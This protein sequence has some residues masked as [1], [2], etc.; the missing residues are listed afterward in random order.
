M[1]SWKER[2]YAFLL[3]RL[4]GPILTRKSLQKLH[5]CLDV[6]VIEG[7]YVLTDIAL[8][9]EYISHKLLAQHGLRVV[10][11]SIRRLEV[12][13]SLPEHGDVERSSSLA[14]RA[15]KLGS[16]SAASD[17]KTKQPSVSL[18]VQVVVEGVLISVEACPNGQPV[19]YS[20]AANEQVDETSAK[21]FLSS[22]L[23]AA[24]SS[25]RL[26]IEFRD[27]R[28]QAV[29]R[30]ELQQQQW[31]EIRA[32]SASY[33]DVM[34]TA[35]AA[36]QDYETVLHKEVKITRF[37]V[38]NGNSEDASMLSSTTV[39]LLEGTSRISVRVIEYDNMN[40]CKLDD[41]VVATPASNSRS[42]HRRVQQDVE[43]VI[44]EKL[45]VSVDAASLHQ[46]RAVITKFQQLRRFD[47][48]ETL[49]A[50]T[51]NFVPSASPVSSAFIQ[52]FDNEDDADFRTL[53]G[54]MKQY[55]EARLL[56]ERKE[57]RGGILVPSF[58]EGSEVTFDTFFDAN[59]QSF[60]RFSS[61]L[62]E[63]ILGATS[64][65]VPADWIHTKL[66][67]H[68]QEGGIKLAFE[69][70]DSPSNTPGE[71]VLLTF[72]E[73]NVSS[74]LSAR[75]FE[76]SISIK[77]FELE[78]ALTTAAIG[79]EAMLAAARTIEIETLLCFS[80][81]AVGDDDDDND[82]LVQAPC[83][84]LQVKT[85][86]DTE[87]DSIEVE[88][89]MQPLELS[90]QSAAISRLAHLLRAGVED[91]HATES[92]TTAQVAVESQLR[93]NTLTAY[94]SCASVSISLPLPVEKDWG[95]LYERCGFSAESTLT[96][97]SALG[98]LFEHV[99]FEMRENKGNLANEASVS[100]YNIVA[101]ASS[102]FSPF[103]VF[104]QKVQRFDLFA[105]C[106]RTEVDP[107]IPFSVRATQFKSDWS[108]HKDDSDGL[109]VKS[110]PKV[111]AISSF[112]AR[113]EDDDEDNRIDQGLSNNLSYLNV[114]SSKS[115][116][117]ELRN[118][119]PQPLMLFDVSKSDIVVSIHIPEIIGDLSAI[120][121]SILKC[122][123][124]SLCPESGRSSG[125]RAER[126]DSSLSNRVAVSINC[127]FVSLAV[128]GDIDLRHTG[129]GTTT[130]TLESFSFLAK[131][132]QFKAH[133]L[134]DGSALRHARILSHELDIFESKCSSKLLRSLIY[135]SSQLSVPFSVLNYPQRA[136]RRCAGSLDKRI[137]SMRRRCTC[138]GDSKAT[139]ILYRSHL[140]SPMSRKSP[141][142]LLD[143]LNMSA[144]TPDLIQNNVYFTVYDATYRHSY[145]SQW[146][147]RLASILPQ[148]DCDDEAGE[149]QRSDEPNCSQSLLRVFLSVADCNVDYCSSVMFKTAS[150]T[151]LRV[152]DFRIS[153]NMLRP[154]SAIQ[155]FSVSLGDVSWYLCNSRFP[156]NFEN[157]HLL[158]SETLLQPSDLTLSPLGL[159]EDVEPDDVLR[160][161]NYRTIL[162]LD[163]MGSNVVISNTTPRL[164]SDPSVCVSFTIGQVFVFACKDSFSRFGSTI[165]E[166][167]AEM[168]ALHDDTLRMLRS[169]SV[170]SRDEKAESKAVVAHAKKEKS[171][172]GLLQDSRPTFG[173]SVKADRK[174][175]FL[176]DGYDWTTIDSDECG[177][178]G[179][180]PGEEQSARW[181]GESVGG[182][183]LSTLSD[184]VTIRSGVGG[185]VMATT[186]S[187]LP[188][189]P[190]IITHHFPLTPVS[191]PIGDGDM[192][193]IKY[194]GLNAKPQVQ[195]RI[196][197][198]DLNIRLRFFDGYDWPE[199]IDEK[200]LTAP[201]GE[202][203]LIPEVAAIANVDEVEEASS[204]RAFV[205]TKKDVEKVD[206]KAKLMGELLSVGPRHGDTF[207][208]MPLPEERR[209]RLNEQA[210]LCRLARR[211]SKYF[212]I[213]A[214]GVSVRLD[215]MEESSEHRL[216]SCLNLKMGDLFLAET[217]SSNRPV[218]MLGEWFNE[219]EHPRDSKDGIIMLK[220]SVKLVLSPSL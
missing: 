64:M 91:C 177:K 211:T 133:V 218:K 151:I 38:L 67:F 190:R 212:Q 174:P 58:D 88:L 25:L 147:K 164:A 48:K 37:A 18:V 106:G 33:N 12:H 16:T 57:V 124:G 116:C 44:N 130:E 76:H 35:A 144:D 160:A 114:N 136:T 96:R 103:S 152:G 163:S 107:C 99:A 159:T 209:R 171:S 63:S 169:K 195:S 70:P 186:T 89:T 13:L 87:N 117:K 3:R 82:L 149:E 121:I 200:D 206:L 104:H 85:T 122:M 59:E 39:A 52:S 216:V 220:V 75:S 173:K 14:W 1:F 184:E 36:S 215:S 113:Q 24:L 27:V 179:I 66:R 23:E 26:S 217:I 56:A 6:S 21:S 111:P 166:A 46:I 131:M 84:S 191:D 141:S 2:L 167:S 74:Q 180:P 153:S 11:A 10:A 79:G 92:S 71:Y 105:L 192:G 154:Q 28:M 140:F 176:L 205:D 15:L 50:E 118:A 29:V 202:S 78:D 197:V 214:A 128:H 142:M 208:N 145:D 102:P 62:K 204:A 139:P 126:E 189:G 7:N 65:G 22:Y 90:Y 109:A 125:I 93:A 45:N 196:L 193:V 156:Y 42:L 175:D 168:T 162:T 132:D 119:D 73:V 41:D 8:N 112:K 134:M 68:L 53:D 115:S 80:S 198:H 60:S 201:R 110:F 120:E 34:S 210:E 97:K 19:S 181:Y 188:L 17:S 161:M 55:Q 9:A 129:V 185:D 51:A 100:C 40:I 77:H 158:C 81:D 165:T 5:E 108:R 170:I 138:N 187:A 137:A 123:I 31:L 148:I 20:D 83:V 172:C 207:Q 54:I 86:S 178:P 219:E 98:F 199:L 157:R 61:V 183:S 182:T 194:A 213:A 143:L 47:M 203:F 127:D 69:S 30:G 72:N 32:Q 146:M 135:L 155:A 101:Y 43:V 95:E 49:A 4:L 94:A 150:R